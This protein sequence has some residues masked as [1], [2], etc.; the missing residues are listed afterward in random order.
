MARA[1]PQRRDVRAGVPRA[2]A[3]ARGEQRLELASFWRESLASAGMVFAL[4][5]GRMRA[6]PLQHRVVVV[7]EN[8]ETVDCLQAYLIRTGMDAQSARSLEALAHLPENVVALILF[9]DEF[10]TDRVLACARTL[11][12][13]RS[14]VLL[15]MVTGR[16]RFF[17]ESLA[18]S[19]RQ[20][21]LV[22][23]KPAFGWTLVDAIRRH[24]EAP[25]AGVLSAGGP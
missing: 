14:R 21:V 12:A 17:S 8:P 4:R 2:M 11:S 24:A 5:V 10:S 19:R 23:A 15:L 1:A 18:S 6:Q 3:T 13:Q 9:P 25:D 16:A 22:L 7:S 20:P